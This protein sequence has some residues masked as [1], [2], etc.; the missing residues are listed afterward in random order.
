MRKILI[1]TFIVS[2]F[3]SSI[4]CAK[5][6]EIIYVEIP[7]YID[8]KTE[9]EDNNINDEDIVYEQP[10]RWDRYN[11]MPDW[12]IEGH[13]TNCD[14]KGNMEYCGAVRWPLDAAGYSSYEI[15]I[16]FYYT[17][18]NYNEWKD[19]LIK[20]DIGSYRSPNDWNMPVNIWNR[21]ISDIPKE[22]NKAVVIVKDKETNKRVQIIELYWKNV[23]R[24]SEPFK[25]NFSGEAHL[26]ID[27]FPYFL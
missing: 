26:H 8:D 13:P 15:A 12:W 5:D 7:T 22:Y 21:D 2:L 14:S 20:Y 6:P 17:L 19:S 4:S 11:R 27:D 23:D 1:I 24:S 18:D 10:E 3:A 9:I 25:Q 16:F